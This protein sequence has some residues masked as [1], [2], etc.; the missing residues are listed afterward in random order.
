MTCRRSYSTLSFATLS[1]LLA[2][3][4]GDVGD[5][6]TD[7]SDATDATVTATSE[8]AEA[9]S[10]V[11]SADATTTTSTTGVIP[12]VIDLAIRTNPANTLGPFGDIDLMGADAV[13]VRIYENGT[14]VFLRDADESPIGYTGFLWGLRELTD[15][16]AIAEADF[17]AQ[18]VLSDEVAFSTGPVPAGLSTRNIVVHDTARA[19]KGLVIL[20]MSTDQDEQIY[21]GIN[22]E[23]EVRWYYFTGAIGARA[24][25]DLKV[26]PDGRLLVFRINGF[27]VIEPWGEVIFDADGEYHH[28]LEPMP[29]GHFLALRHAD[30][31]V[32]VP[33]TGINEDIESDM[34]VEADENGQ[35]VREWFLHDHLDTSY[36][37]SSLSLNGTPLDWSHANALVWDEDNSRILMSV[38]HLSWVIAIDWPS[39]DVLWRLGP[40]GDFTFSGTDEQWNYNQHSPQIQ[41]DG[42]ILLYDNGNDRPSAERYSR[43]AI[44]DLDENAMTADLVWDHR[45][46]PRTNVQGDADRL[47]NGNIL[48]CAGGV[49]STGNPARIIEASGDAA[50][51]IVWELSL[52]DGESVYRAT[53]IDEF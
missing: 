39:G 45:I 2:C 50:S 18:T 9:T 35:T 46:S 22:P 30:T 10:T 21:V 13:R 24:G 44:F 29:N 33:P 47:S 34:I 31:N 48:A 15:Y 32:F 4:G 17:G 16:T 41:A 40:G 11:T 1:L 38:R 3:G 8:T 37:P 23:G 53:P 52:P 12:E 43:A 36:W 28:D 20:P 51:E 6:A 19:H 27:Q 7:T 26:L 49:L 14:E 5:S 42:T 25:G